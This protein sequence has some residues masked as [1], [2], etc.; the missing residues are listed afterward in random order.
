MAYLSKT[1]PMCP[2]IRLVWLKTAR[3][4]FQNKCDYSITIIF[5]YKIAH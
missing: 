4:T 3:G 1:A 5:N 2:K